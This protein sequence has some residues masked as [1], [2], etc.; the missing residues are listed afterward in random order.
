MLQLSVCRF[1]PPHEIEHKSCSS[2]LLHLLAEGVEVAEGGPDTSTGAPLTQEQLHPWLAWTDMPCQGRHLICRILVGPIEPAPWHNPHNPPPPLPVLENV[3][4][5]PSVG[6]CHVAQLHVPGVSTSSLN[7]HDGSLKCGDQGEQAEQ[8]DQG[9]FSRGSP[10][11]GGSDRG[12][13]GRRG[14]F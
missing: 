13:R 3:T 1:P 5:L 14:R 12:R 4:Q 2:L 6:G 10:K 11:A 7:P 9:L 8:G